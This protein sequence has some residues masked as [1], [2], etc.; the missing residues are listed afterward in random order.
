MKRIGQSA[1]SIILA[2][3]LISCIPSAIPQAPAI[4]TLPTQSSSGIAAGS[5]VAPILS[6]SAAGLEAANERVYEQVAPSVVLLRVVEKAT[7][8]VGNT[9]GSPSN[10]PSIASG[11]GFVWDTAGHIVTNF[12]VV[13]NAANIS[14]T[15]LD[16]T[17]TA[18]KI[19]GADPSSDLAVLQVAVPADLLKPVT[20]GDSS[21]VKVGELAIAIGY[22]F[23]LESTMTQGIISGLSRSLPIDAGSGTP[24][25]YTIPDLIQTDA[26]INP[27]NSGG[28]LLNENGEVIGITNAI[29]SPAGG[30]S[31]GVGFA[32]PSA[33]LSQVAP[34][35]ITDGKYEH[36]YLGISGIMLTPDLAAAMNLDAG[37]R[38]ILVETVAKGSPA[39]IAGIRPSTREITLNGTAISV[40]GDIITA[41]DNH[42]MKSCEDMVR[43][44][45][46]HTEAGQ[47]AT[48]TILRDGNAVN[49]DVILAANPAG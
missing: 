23:G 31:V 33:I 48:F 26:S 4:S 15:F 2:V 11:S 21:A 19:V 47:K 1:F 5:A 22:P 3:I 45:F 44:L 42:P 10:G 35:L 25:V 24:S 38:G 16:G 14:V 37:T 9:S 27:G 12:H 41:V 49:V 30:G 39:D 7:A 13:D 18:A 29:I 20:V 40:G 28:V 34:K 32:I 6:G 46:I 8:P 43:Y 36:T 17:Q